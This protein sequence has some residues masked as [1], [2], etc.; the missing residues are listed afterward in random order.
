MVW[1]RWYPQPWP[2]TPRCNR[3]WVAPL[4][5]GCQLLL[6]MLMSDATSQHQL[7]LISLKLT[8]NSTDVSPVTSPFL[9]L[10]VLFFLG[11]WEGIW[12]KYHFYYLHYLSGLTILFFYCG[13][14]DVSYSLFSHA[15]FHFGFSHEVLLVSLLRTVD[16]YIWFCLC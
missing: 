10:I 15:Y 7:E 6:P 16:R 11:V 9:I 5:Y 3:S 1:M 4:M 13:S 8:R 2:Q 14:K 12:L